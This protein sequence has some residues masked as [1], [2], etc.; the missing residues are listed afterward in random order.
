MIF[1]I[2]NIILIVLL[3]LLVVVLVIWIYDE[4]TYNKRIFTENFTE[5]TISQNLG[6]QESV[7]I[8]NSDNLSLDE[9][10][11]LVN[12]IL[13]TIHYNFMM[14]ADCSNNTKCIKDSDKEAI[15]N[16]YKTSQSQPIEERLKIFETLT[17]NYKNEYGDMSNIYWDFKLLD[18]KNDAT[19]DEY[20]YAI[21]KNIAVNKIYEYVRSN[22]DIIPVE[23][24]KKYPLEIPRNVLQELIDKYF[25]LDMN[26]SSI[27][28]IG[29]QNAIDQN[30][31]NQNVINKST[32]NNVGTIDM[33]LSEPDK[34][35][36]NKPSTNQSE[37]VL[38]LKSR[39]PL[40]QAERNY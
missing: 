18:I 14:I 9:E 25:K 30:A 31:V 16:A 2:K 36:Y 23:I 8:S 28:F 34:Y 1:D 35:I 32:S 11:L 21:I 27:R 19:L 24:K 26:D 13:T 15:Y 12:S 38:I 10:I 37:E 17:E 29:I 5:T 39:G 40:I 33:I 7:N 22:M 3:I 4:G 6:S 20:Y